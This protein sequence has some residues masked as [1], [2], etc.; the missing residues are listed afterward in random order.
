M[1]TDALT[2]GAAEP[3]PSGLMDWSAQT[4]FYPPLPREDLILRPRLLN[5]LDEALARH[6]LTLLSAPAGYGKTTL[7]AARAHTLPQR[8]FAWLTLEQEDND[9]AHFLKA[10]I[11]ALRRANPLLGAPAE[12]LLANLSNPGAQARQV[13]NV[14]INDLLE[15]L[16][17]PLAFILDDLHLVA[18]PIIFAALE[19]LAERIPP[20]LHLVVGTRHDPPLALARLRARGQLAELGAAALR[21]TW[22]ETTQFLNDKLQLALSEKSIEVL[23]ARTEG[24]PT[25]LRLLA[26]SLQDI[27]PADR[28][29]FISSIARTDRY[30]FEF[31]AEE[32]LNRQPPAVRTFLLETSILAELNPTL[33]RA[34]TQRQDAEQALDD[35]YRRNLFV[36]TPGKRAY[37][38]HALFAEFLNQRLSQELPERLHDLHRRAAQAQANS[39]RAVP[40]YL[41]AEMWESAAETIETI[42]GELLR[43]GLLDTLAGWIHALPVSVR[44][45]RPRLLHLLGSCAWEKGELDT[46]YRFL[47]EA[48]AG[49]ES[50]GDDKAEGEVLTDLA[51]CA[52]LR[53]DVERSAALFDRALAYTL[54][55]Q[56]R[57][58]ALMGRA[59]L[60]FFRNDLAQAAA[61]F[62]A[63]TTVMEESAD[64]DVLRLLLIRLNAGYAALPGGKERV[65]RILQQA[66]IYF[67]DQISPLRVIIEELTALIHIWR[68][69][70]EEAI[71]AGQATL[72]VKERLG[73]GYPFV[74]VDAATIVV[75][76]YTAR[77]DYAAAECYVGRLFEGV[78]HVALV[79]QMKVA[80]LFVVARSYWLQGR[81]EQVR[82]LYAQICAAEHPGELPM[83]AGFRARLQGM[84]AM[85]G[86]RYVE[87]ERALRQAVSIEDHEHFSTLFGSSRVLL[88]HFYVARGRADEAL[89]VL[90]PIL[91]ESEQ[92]GMRSFI[93]L[94]GAAAVP[95]LRLAVERGI[96][97]DYAA[98]LLNLLGVGGEPRPVFVAETGET[99]TPREV[100]ILRRI[101][102]GASNRVIAEQ[103]VIDEGTVKSHVHHIL[104]KLNAASRTAAAARARELH[105]V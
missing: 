82:D 3:Y 93:M 22:D 4:K 91:A 62:A 81:L 64:P 83:D 90:A 100:E 12:T 44:E 24:W 61:D 47:E 94:N 71:R 32:V 51:N 75:D 103:L 40:H 99:L 95:A 16:D 11:A 1:D 42:G 101:A 33:C 80:S 31:L 59:G 23:Y 7:L 55:P 34:V 70:L 53:A 6:P 49:F 25:G 84:L 77:G 58:Q 15:N 65:E 96:H 85:S 5:L 60:G 27:P 67:G 38:Y 10:L 56:R 21:F 73:G 89:T 72:A 43:E 74:G 105:L 2:A 8:S 39:S 36:T 57:V 26:T 63:A 78:K 98:H 45:T 68:G 104:R 28:A 13:V 76:S 29:A 20:L 92:R 14:L 102:A 50:A 88:A 46:A 41:A 18:E 66:R 69:E 17:S 37:R 35:L 97:A 79:E 87:A 48:R 9:P 19:H 30:V 86:G 54:S 52:M